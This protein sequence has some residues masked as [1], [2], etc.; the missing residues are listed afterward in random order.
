MDMIP[1][2]HSNL[3]AYLSSLGY[4]LY[5]RFKRTGKIEDLEESI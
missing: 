3:V 5:S 4:K 2:D 1:Q